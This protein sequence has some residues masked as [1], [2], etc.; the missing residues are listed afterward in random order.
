MANFVLASF[1][2]GFIVFCYQVAVFLAHGE[3]ITWSVHDALE[4]FRFYHLVD[5]S[6]CWPGGRWL[7]QQVLGLPISTFFFVVPLMVLLL[8]E[9]LKPDFE[10][11][12]ELL[13]KGK[14]LLQGY[15]ASR[16]RTIRPT[17]R[18]YR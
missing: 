18:P 3:W 17:G 2:L 13:I 8:I 15:R 14:M 12:C 10:R 6:K 11:L 9:L 4:P 5:S 1:S 7:A 16:G